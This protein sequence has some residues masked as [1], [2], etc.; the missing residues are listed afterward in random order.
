MQLW[1]EGI[2]EGRIVGKNHCHGDNESIHPQIAYDSNR[3]YL[4]LKFNMTVLN[5]VHQVFLFQKKRKHEEKRLDQ[6]L[7]TKGERKEM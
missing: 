3:T 6:L 5:V 7:L 1:L 4:L 2:V